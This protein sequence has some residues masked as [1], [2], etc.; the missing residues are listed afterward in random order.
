MSP[1]ESAA[2][3]VSVALVAGALLLLLL[4]WLTNPHKRMDFRGRHCIVTGGS[5]GIGKEVAKVTAFI[6]EHAVLCDTPSCTE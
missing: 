4:R 2:V 5:S 1:G 3:G 6:I